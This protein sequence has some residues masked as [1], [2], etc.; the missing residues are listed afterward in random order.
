[1]KFTYGLDFPPLVR[2]FSMR[3]GLFLAA[4]IGLWISN[5]ANAVAWISLLIGA[6]FGVV[7]AV[8]VWS[9]LTGK[10]QMRDRLLDSVVW[11]GDEKVLDIGCG[12]GLLL[13]G[14]AKRLQTGKSTGVDLWSKHD[15]TGNTA[16]AARDNATKESVLPK[17]K[18]DTADAQKLPYADASF[19]VVVSANTLHALPDPAKALAEI[20]RVLKPGGQLRIFDISDTG[21]Y[22]KGLQALGLTEVSVSAPSWLWCKPSRTVSAKKQL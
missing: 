11:K 10:L 1:V 22:A 8:D 4:G 5:G 3:A 13:I 6:G 20:V 9:S 15:L 16:D 19:D 21:E 12:S 17:I 18:I 2:D 14:A 7:V